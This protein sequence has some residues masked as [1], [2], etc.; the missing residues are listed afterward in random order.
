MRAIGVGAQHARRA[1]KIRSRARSPHR[2]L[3]RRRLRSARA[4]RGADAGGRGRLRRPAGGHRRGG[5]RHLQSVRG[6][7]GPARRDG[8]DGR[9]P[10]RLHR[11]R[12]G[13]RPRAR[14]R[15]ARAPTR[16]RRGR[17]SVRGVERAGVARGGG[18]R[19]RR[20]GVAGA[21]DRQDGRQHHAGPRAPVPARR[22][23]LQLGAEP[24]ATGLRR[25]QYRASRARPGRESR[26]ELG[27]G[28]GAADRHGGL[29]G[30]HAGGAARPR[31]V[32]GG[33]LLTQRTR[34]AVREPRGRGRG[35]T[36]RPG[37]APR[38]RRPRDLVQHRDLADPERRSAAARP[39]DGYPAC[40]PARRRPGT[41]VS[42]GSICST[43]RRS[44]CTRRCPSCRRRRTLAR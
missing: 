38:I 36:S 13:D 1:D 42:P 24:H 25:A 32:G 16:R 9:R 27:D 37:R 30:R 18:G 19:D 34:A 15:G 23:H 21:G 3:P 28:A 11:R 14:R 43:S 10:G 35:R 44:A 40:P 26:R 33:G 5:A 8:V 2:G 22:A 7:S 6:L 4:T 20:P 41:A 31:R 12:H 29:R 17:P 39:S